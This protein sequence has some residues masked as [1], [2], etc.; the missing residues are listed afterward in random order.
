MENRAKSK[1]NRQ[2]NPNSLANLKKG[3]PGRKTKDPEIAKIF[4]VNCPD[5][6]QFLV[7]T[8]ND[9]NVKIDTRVKC[10]ETIV[11]RV[12]GKPQQTVDVGNKD[13]EAFK[14]NN[15]DLSRLT[16]EELKELLG[17]GD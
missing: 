1:K 15:I 12:L 16:V 7:D 8:M 10:A 9:E 3:G 4:E 17:D 13:G 6:A 2:V 11:E 14:T 5:A